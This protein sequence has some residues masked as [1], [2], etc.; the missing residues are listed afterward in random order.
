MKHQARPRASRTRT[1]STTTSSTRRSTCSRRSTRIIGE[2]W[3]DYAKEISAFE[4][5]RPVHRH[6]VAGH[7]QHRS[8]PTRRSP[9]KTIA[10]Q[11]GRDRLVGHLDDRRQGGAP[12]LRVQVDGLDRLARRSTPRWPSTSA[13]R[14]RNA[15]ACDDDRGQELLRR[16]TTPRDADYASKIWY[17]TTPIK[18]V[19]RRAT[20]VTLHRLRRVDARPGPRSRADA[21]TAVQTAAAAAC[22]HRR[23]GGSLRPAP[24]I[25]GSGSARC[26]RRRCSGCVV[27]Y[28]GSLAVTAGHGVLDASTTSPATIDRSSP[29][30]NIQD[31]FTDPTSTAR[32]RSA[33]V[34]VAVAG[35]AHR[36]AL[37]LPIAFFMAK[38]APRRASAV[39]LVIAV[40]TPLWA[41]YLVKA[42]AWRVML[43]H[44][45]VVDWA[46]QP[47]GLHGPGYGLP[48]TIITLVLPVAAVHDPA[49]LRRARAGARLAARGSADLGAQ[50]RG[51]RSASWSCPLILPARHR[52]LDLHVLAVA[53]RLH[54]GQA[55]SAARPS[56]SA[57]S[58]TTTSAPRTT[59]RSRPPLALDPGRR[60]G[61]LPVAVTPHRRPGEPL[62]TP[63]C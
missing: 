3:A 8:T 60:H 58:S 25:R 17:W 53:R 18:R 48:A 21:L 61:R 15:Q 7:R 20:D 22:A 16:R 38:V 51:G 10:A 33:R 37:A 45:G 26:S 42:Y 36:P 50:A 49:D 56:C 34:G 54:H 55:S 40:L 30:D 6:D 19:P 27:L 2:Y 29:L 28:L 57:T 13:R 1:R 59:C 9:V 44:G 23:A 62:S 5:G 47:F 52:R 39:L 11:G 32:S 31:L 41:S 4:T 35:D 24:R 46:L 14:R 12:E 43:I 63:C